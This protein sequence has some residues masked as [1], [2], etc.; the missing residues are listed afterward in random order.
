MDTAQAHI[1]V[2]P[3]PSA[4]ELSRRSNV[5]VPLVRF[6]QL[7]VKMYLLAQRHHGNSRPTF[8]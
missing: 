3:L 4:R 7:N 2:A 1:D 6:L 5:L 8:G